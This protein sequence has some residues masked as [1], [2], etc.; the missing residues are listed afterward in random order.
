MRI[1][2]GTPIRLEA[3]VRAMG[4]SCSTPI[5]PLQVVVYITTSSQEVERGDV[6]VAL[7]GDHYDGHDFLQEVCERGA[8][9]VVCHKPVSIPC[10]T[11]NHIHVDDTLEALANLAQD[12]ASHFPHKTIAITGSVG[13]TTTRHY[14]A[15]L[16]G[17]KYKVHESLY[18]Y[19]NLLGV[20]LS[21]LTAPKDTEYLVLELGMDGKGQISRM[22]KLVRPDVAVITNIGVSHIEKLGSQE[23]ICKAKLEILHGMAQDKLLIEGSDPY[24][25]KYA[26]TDAITVSA[27]SSALFYATEPKMT[28]RGTTFHFV[29][30]LETWRDLHI[31]TVGQHTLSCASFGIA[32]TQ[33]ESVPYQTVKNALGSYETIFQR[34]SMLSIGGV[35]IILDA[36]NACPASMKAALGT[37]YLTSNE[38]GGD[39]VALLGDMQE[40][41]SD[42]IQ[43]HR[44][45]GKEVARIGVS[46]LF[47]AG[48]MAC[49]YRDGAILGG[50]AY[51]Q[52][53]ILDDTERAEQVKEILPYLKPKTTFLIKGSRKSKLETLLPYLQKSLI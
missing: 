17:A 43:Y 31:P 16:L 25:S 45:I 41:G 19:N 14:I 20:S 50:M 5:S 15:T 7:K 24:L 46:H 37:A 40:L 21:I 35:T 33:L 1:K 39:I 53:T 6:F 12:Y 48:K 36:Y 10:P 23:E 44:E 28:S 38:S 51:E 9:A 47:L 11:P 13:K 42:S 3:L 34:Q 4:G 2:L 26:P 49:H 27:S 18:N 22:S 8:S 52:I 30:P 29:S 32:V